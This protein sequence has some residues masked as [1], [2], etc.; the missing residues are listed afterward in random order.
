MLAVRY[1]TVNTKNCHAQCLGAL[2]GT[3]TSCAALHCVLFFLSSIVALPSIPTC[4]HCQLVNEQHNLLSCRLFL[5]FHH[6]SIESSFRL[7]RACIPP[8]EL[9]TISNTSS[10]QPDLNMRCI[11][12]V[13]AAAALV[14]IAVAGNAPAIMREPIGDTYSANLPNTGGITGAIKGSA[15]PN[16]QGTSFQITFYNLPTNEGNLS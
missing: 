10:S 11:S 12:R 1:T 5:F 7:I 9:F 8:G 2:V 15:A 4:R 13:A 14:S 6:T 3:S 16:G